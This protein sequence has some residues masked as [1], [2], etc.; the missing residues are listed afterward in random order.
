MKNDRTMDLCWNDF[1]YYWSSMK[2]FHF[3]IFRWL[4]IHFMFFLVF[5]IVALSFLGNQCD[6]IE[7][8]LVNLRFQSC[9]RV[10]V[11]SLFFLPSLPS[12]F[13]FCVSLC[14][15]SLS[16]YFCLSQSKILIFIVTK[17]RFGIGEEDAISCLSQ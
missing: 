5:C 13:C 8:T 4:C 12:C 3:G 1:L 7:R 15:S 10:F 14:L 17:L 16:L 11:Y 9:P 6:I 2:V